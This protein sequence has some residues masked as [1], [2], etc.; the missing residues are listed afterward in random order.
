MTCRPA[1]RIGR[2]FS[3]GKHVAWRIWHQ[4]LRLS[5]NSSSDCRMMA[6]PW[7]P[8]TGSSSLCV[9]WPALR[10]ARGS[11][12]VSLGPLNS[13]L[14]RTSTATALMDAVGSRAALCDESALLRHEAA[15]CLGQQNQPEAVPILQRLLADAS[16]DPMYARP[17]G[18]QPPAQQP[19]LPFHVG[20]P[21]SWPCWTLVG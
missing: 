6:Q 1:L 4:S 8:S 21:D 7:L 19:G 9:A 5:G 16:E 15:Y 10:H 12:Q 18:G 20:A 11:R 17:E 14:A 2:T 13:H 3:Q